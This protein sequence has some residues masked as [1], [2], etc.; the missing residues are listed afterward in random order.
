M[1]WKKASK[2]TKTTAN[3]LDTSP[4]MPM[5]DCQPTDVAPMPPIGTL[6][7]VRPGES[8]RVKRYN[9]GAEGP[10]S[11]DGLFE[12]VQGHG[13]SGLVQSVRSASAPMFA[14]GGQLTRA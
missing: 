8:D 7:Y 12:V 2:T 4:K 14:W 11:T 13:P 10:I 1:K 3:P 5:S 6:V 9:D